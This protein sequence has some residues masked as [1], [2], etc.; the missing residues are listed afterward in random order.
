[1]NSGI[2]S[3]VN[4][5]NQNRYIGSTSDLA[6]RWS[7]HKVMLNGSRHH[8]DRL[9]MDWDLFSNIKFNFE[10]LEYCEA[11]D[12]ILHDR[13]QHWINYFDASNPEK[14]YNVE[15]DAVRHTHSKETRIKISE[16]NKALKRKYIPTPETIERLRA[17][18]LGQ[19]A[20]NEG[21]KLPRKVK[22]CKEC[23]KEFELNYAT[24]PKIFCSKFCSD[25]SRRK[26]IDLLCPI[27][28][29]VFKRRPSEID[30]YCSREC[31]YK[32]L[33]NNKHAVKS[34]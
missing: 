15:S 21:L 10:I 23:K 22:I 7:Q 31:Y 24:E 4:I 34:T 12:I 27:C 33:I 28:K 16:S 30:T 25:K 2:Y 1:M 14:G 26:L 3:I 9:Q 29:Q 17:S 13:E 18:H 11:D 19:P 6:R 20:W 5:E 8:S 32:T